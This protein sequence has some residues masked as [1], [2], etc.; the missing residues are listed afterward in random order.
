ML[1]L[2]LNHVNNMGP[3]YY[4]LNESRIKFPANS[5]TMDIVGEADF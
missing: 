3:V 4:S 5:L 1:G 2:N